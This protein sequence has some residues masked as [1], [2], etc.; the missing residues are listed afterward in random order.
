MLAKRYLVKKIPVGI[1]FH[2]AQNGNF[3]IVSLD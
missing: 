1:Q 3:K 2:A